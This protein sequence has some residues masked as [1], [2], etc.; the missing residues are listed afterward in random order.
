L[1]I[2]VT[3][4]AAPCNRSTNNETGTH[5]GCGKDAPLRRAV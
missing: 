2:A 4:V 1:A 5:L 3:W